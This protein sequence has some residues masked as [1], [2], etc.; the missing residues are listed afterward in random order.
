MKYDIV[1]VGTGLGGLVCGYILGKNG[2]KVILLEKNA[3]IG[4]CLQSFQR[5]GILYDTGMHYIGGMDK[6][7]VLNRLFSYLDLNEN[8]K[9][10]KLDENG[11]DIISFPDKQYSFAMGFENFSEKL[12]ANFPKES[13]HI[14]SYSESIQKIAHESSLYNLQ[15]VKNNS[16]LEVESIKTSVNEFLES[17][18]PNK[19]LQNVL[20]GNLP[21]YAGVKDKTPLYIHAL[22]NNLYIQS[23]YRIVGGSQSIANSLANS[24]KLMGGEVLTNSEVT[25]FGCNT[26]G[27][28]SVRL[29][30]GETIEGKQFIS[31][32][33]PQATFDKLNTPFIRNVFKE[34]IS[35]LDNTISN[36]T[37]YIKFKK[38]TVKYLNSNFYHYNTEN[39]WD[40]NNYT[41]QQFPINYLFMHIP[42]SVDSIYSDGAF[43]ISYMHFEEVRKWLGTK[44]GQRGK[45][46][47]EFKAEKAN[48]LLNNLQKSFPG[49]LSDIEAFSSSTPLTYNDY[50][51][52]KDGSMYGVLR[53][54][55]FPTQTLV[56]QRTRIPNLFMTG[57]NI[58]SHGMLGVTIGA[59]ITCAEFLGINN[60]I[61]DINKV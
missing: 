52:T 6:G 20:A 9:L 59:I 56:S 39:V 19:T 53:D 2:Y 57:Q 5:N 61:K 15:E 28:T 11:F 55:N 38:N 50:T 12:S 41:Q 43:L 58:N 35:K 33:H 34:R 23:A 54:K 60:I 29:K 49:I 51:A 30:N 1:I 17:I 3:Q 42:A 8:V 46:Y 14:K 16:Y 21:L 13:L 40:C 27:I 18:T 26:L 31:N 32:I 37:V 44:I 48:L 10:R 22:I 45:E 25:E 36:F 7:Q 4:G 24:I 47:E